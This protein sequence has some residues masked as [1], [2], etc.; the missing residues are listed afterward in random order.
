MLY[1][2]LQISS[3]DMHV[4]EQIQ[5]AECHLHQSFFDILRT[6]QFDLDALMFVRM[7]VA[8]CRNA[9]HNYL[10]LEYL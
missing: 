10:T 8:Q 5:R 4:Y 7:V 9:L 1:L 3:L 6:E 2:V